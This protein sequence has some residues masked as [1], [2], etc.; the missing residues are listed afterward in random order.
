MGFLLL[1]VPTAACAVPGDRGR[2]PACLQWWPKICSPLTCYQKTD[3]T[4]KYMT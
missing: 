1:L 3:S 2:V 4:K